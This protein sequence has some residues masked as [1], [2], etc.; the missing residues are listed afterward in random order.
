[1]KIEKH[2]EYQND[3]K[4]NIEVSYNKENE[5]ANEILD[6]LFLN[7]PYTLDL[8]EIIYIIKVIYQN[9]DENIYVSILNGQELSFLVDMQNGKV[10]S[11]YS[12]KIVDDKKIYAIKY[13]QNNGYNFRVYD[14]KKALNIVQKEVNTI[15]NLN[16]IY[17][18]PVT[19]FEKIIVETYNL[20][21]SNYP[22]FSNEEDRCKCKYLLCT[23]YSLNLGY[24]NIDMTMYNNKIYSDDLITS[25]KRIA[26]LGKFSKTNVKLPSDYKDALLKL[27]NHLDI[28]LEKL[29]SLAIALYTK[30]Y[31]SSY[32]ENIDTNGI[33]ETLSR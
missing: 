4:L 23:L 10:V 28:D 8:K 18:F 30:R 1:M 3:L 25:F 12:E 16:N 31:I 20:V 33:Y 6:N 26:P 21:F 2:Y 24:F 5:K 22:D 11:Y 14:D 9:S 13:S 19:D 32:D 27:K 15:N 17:L 29:K 7:K